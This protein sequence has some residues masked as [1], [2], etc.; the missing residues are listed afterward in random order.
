MDAGLLSFV[1]TAGLALL[2]LFGVRRLAVARSRPREL[3]S[4]GPPAMP[5]ATG[6]AAPP[7]ASS[8]AS[9]SPA[10]HAALERVAEQ[11]V[12]FHTHLP[13]RPGASSFWGGVPLVPPGF[14][15]PHFTPE[16]GSPRALSFILQVDCAAIPPQGRLGL[17]PERGTLYVFMDLD[18]GV[19]WRWQVLYADA[20]A[21][22]LKPAAVPAALPRAYGQR[23][24]WGWPHHDDDWPRLLPRFSFDPILVR[25]PRLPPL[26][27]DSDD[28]R[29]V[30]PGSVDVAVALAEVPGAIVESAWVQTHYKDGVV[31][32]PFENFPQDWQAVTITLGH[33]AEALRGRHLARMEKR[34]GGEVQAEALRVTLAEGLRV[35]GERVDHADAPLSLADRE[36][37][38][39]FIVSVQ[40]VSVFVLTQAANDSL[41][42]TLASHP[43]AAEVLDAQAWAFARS[44]H[45]LGLRDARGVRADPHERMLSAPREVQDG[46]AERARQWLLLLE[47]SDNPALGHHLAE[48]VVQ[49][50]IRPEDLAERRF[51]RVEIHA[52]AY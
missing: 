38:W 6:P 10:V 14:E 23:A 52:T 9:P 12:L 31:Q 44:R 17:M 26:H 29:L 21:D 51:D 3:A 13:P 37:F 27:A 42:A 28:E 39:A 34:P 32:R 48:G 43:A 5:P 47:I 1:L 25:G 36:A 40:P 2:V 15:W 7:P 30:W 45:A 11:A 41:D 18:W 4:K 35:W 24:T 49:F 19:H 46:A 33:L 16:G 20:E 22:S 8:P 50:F